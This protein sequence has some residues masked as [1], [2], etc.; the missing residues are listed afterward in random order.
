[1]RIDLLAALAIAALLLAPTVV[2]AQSSSYANAP[3][4]EH[5][6]EVAQAAALERI[7]AAA[8]ALAVTGASDDDDD[9]AET[10]DD[11]QAATHGGEEE[12]EEGGPLIDF[13]LLRASLAAASPA[14]EAKLAAAIEK[15]VEGAEDGKDI[16]EPAEEVIRLSEKARGELLTPAVT[17]MPGFQAALMAS[18]LL[19]EGG[20]AEGYEEATEGEASAY[21]VGYF[22][23]Q[24]IKWLW[25]GLAGRA[26][27]QQST[28]VKAMLAMLDE[29]FPSQDMPERLS[30]D[31]EQAEAPA[32][33]LVG[34]LEGIADAELYLGRDLAA[35]TAV[36]HDLA[37]KGCTLLEAGKEALGVE[38]LRVAAAYY[39]QTVRDTLG[40]MAPEA[41]AAIAEVLEELD[42]GEADEVANTCGPLLE[43]FA[44]GQASLAP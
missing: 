10:A 2:G 18:L 33:Q 20:V 43:A 32:Q 4:R 36:V 29:L 40:M 31:P 39:G 17:D 7:E 38:E 12:D 27:P 13:G 6:M 14:L 37:V 41:A 9:E 35:A 25:E 5:P 28:D 15:M 26:S 19:D 22:A 21:A 8:R 34:L 24:R 44:A 16:A 30:S 23:L 1:M 11:D 42:E 3:F